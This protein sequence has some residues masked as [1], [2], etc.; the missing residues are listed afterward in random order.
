MRPW[1]GAAPPLD[2]AR[3]ARAARER[4]MPKP[5]GLLALLVSLACL[6]PGPS[7]AYRLE[8][9]LERCIEIRASQATWIRGLAVLELRYR[10]VQSTAQCGCKSAAAAFASFAERPSG[11]RPLTSGVMTLAHNDL[12]SLPLSVDRDLLGTATVVVTL[13]CEASR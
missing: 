10:E 11:R 8:N 12:V 5:A 6:R 2:P 3:A 1:P 4:P 7:I 13:A 9:E